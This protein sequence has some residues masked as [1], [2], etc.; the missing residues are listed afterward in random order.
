MIT[1]KIS[2]TDIRLMETARGRVL[3]WAS[4]SLEPGMFEE[5]VIS[6]PG[7]LGAAIK[8]LMTS[9]GIKGKNLIVSVSGLYSL[10]RTVTVSGPGEVTREAVL[11]AAME[12]M[13]LSEDELY[14]SWQTVATV[15]GRQQV[16]V[17]GVPRDALDG[18]V[19]ALKAAGINPH[20]LDLKTMALARAV[21]REQALILNIQS[22]SFDMAVV[23]DGVIE[24]M[25]T[26]AWQPE[27]LTVEEKAE[28]LA[29][30]LEMTVGFYESQ[31]PDFPLD[32]TT[33]LFVTGQ[34]SRDFTLMENL[35]AR[36]E[37]PFEPIA[38]PLAYPQHLPVSQYAVNIGLALKG[39]AAKGPGQSGYS[40]PDI[41]LLPD[42][43]RAWRPSARQ[44]HFFLGIVVAIVLLFPFYQLTTGATGETASLK[45]RYDA[46]NRLLEQ[47]QVEIRSREPLQK[48]VNE[49]NTIVG[50]GGGFVEDLEVINSLAEELG[51]EMQTITHSGGS[52]TF[53]CQ[54][55]SYIV[56]REYIT[57]LKESGRFSSV[58]AVPVEQAQYPPEYVKEG[59]L[60]L[61]R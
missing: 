55:K 7:A 28:H 61:T 43:Y 27:E 20:L 39:T 17:V 34:M 29:T 11:E 5:G 45:V 31:H 21:D 19:Q 25:H 32:P 23:V 41:N 46:V 47:R 35:Q 4:R 14:L 38:P 37:Y 3:R 10:V 13:P 1:L 18:E 36:V 59:T 57:A 16:L 8:Q 50:M 9:S 51:I 42:I 60:T 54:A 44:M 26:T 33:P 58:T 2:N 12:V 6:N 49:Y 22:S 52:I 30:A 56:F 53:N 40:L 48:A 24:V 15:G